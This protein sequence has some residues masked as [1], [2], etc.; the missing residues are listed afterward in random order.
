MIIDSFGEAV[1]QVVTNG[2]SPVL[3]ASGLP[4]PPAF[5]DAPGCF[6]EKSSWGTSDSSTNPR[7]SST[8]TDPAKTHAG[9]PDGDS[10]SVRSPAHTTAPIGV[11]SRTCWY[12]EGIGSASATDTVQDIMDMATARP[13]IVIFCIMGIDGR[14]QLKDR[15][16][17]LGEGSKISRVCQVD[18]DRPAKTAHKMPH[19]CLSATSWRNQCPTAATSGPAATAP[20]AQHRFRARIW[21]CMVSAKPQNRYGDNI[22]SDQNVPKVVFFHI[23]AKR[24]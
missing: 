17:G 16:L 10:I 20:G 14:Y 24:A 8:S 2:L 23:R 9:F 22:T 12:G 5:F 6:A 13:N 15:K 7:R 3:D 11:P 4:V 19:S 21:T 1:R 18:S